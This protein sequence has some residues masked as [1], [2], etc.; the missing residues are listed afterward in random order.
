MIILAVDYGLK[1]TGLAVCDRD[2]IICSPL[3]VVQQKDDG[4]A[5]KIAQTA[6]DYK[7][8]ALVF[9][10]P[11]NMDGTEGKQ[12]KKVRSFA[13]KAGKIAGLEVFFQDERLT[14]EFASDMLRP[15]ELTRKKKKKRLDAVAAAAILK[16]FTEKRKLE[17]S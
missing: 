11:Y 15:A 3:E 10:L 7:A 5:E 2:E 13:E 4:L 9:G 8:E 12:A 6:Q 14:S 1:R 17:N 16:A